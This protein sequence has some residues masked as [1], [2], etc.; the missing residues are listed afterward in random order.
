MGNFLVSK[1][2]ESV[3]PKTKSYSDIKLEFKDEYCTSTETVNSLSKSK[4]NNSILS[5][6]DTLSEIIR[7]ETRI[8]KIETTTLE[9]LK[10]IS[11]DIH[12]LYKLI[13]SIEKK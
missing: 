7:L 1:L 2:E 5:E 10:L 6:V 3:L 9:N 12:T 8:E 4:E 13:N 11:N